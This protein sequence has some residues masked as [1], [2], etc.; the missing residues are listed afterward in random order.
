MIRGLLQMSNNKNFVLPDK[1]NL[2]YGGASSV[3]SSDLSLQI[4]EMINHS[5]SQQCLD[6]LDLQQRFLEKYQSWISTSKLNSVNGLN[7]FKAAAYSNG[8]SEGF[9]KFYL[10]NNKRRF[11]CLRGEY[12]YHMAAWR[13]YF[14]DWKYIDQ[15]PLAENDAVVISLPFADLGCE[16]PQTQ[17]ILDECYRLGI[18]V[19]L[20]CAY[21]GICQ[22]IAFD[23]THPAITD[24]TFS[25]SKFLPVAHL[26]I[27][28]RLTKVDDDDSLLVLNKTKYTNRIG[29]AVGEQ[30]LE[31]FNPDWIVNEYAHRQQ[32]LCQML[33][34]TPS[35][36]IIF[37]IDYEN[38]YP[39]YN[40]GA[41][42]NRLCLAKYLNG[43]QLLN[44]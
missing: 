6:K 41:A 15:E 7:L 22:G 18:P 20:D 39:E 16:H 34:V 11:R 25:L 2:P 1:K 8:T 17:N 9:D 44:V 5:V 31:K 29:L 37:G 36:C 26:R 13:N 35:N 14:P 43:E 30:I 40:R 42:F 19:L 38:K 21:F 24:V 27:G 3:I 23:L 32:Q 10:R 12:M 33:N 4:N 28:M